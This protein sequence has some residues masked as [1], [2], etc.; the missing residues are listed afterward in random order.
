MSER[1]KP[2]KLSISFSYTELVVVVFEVSPVGC[3]DAD[4]LTF[5]T[6]PDDVPPDDEVPPDDDAPPDDGA[7]PDG[8]APP[9]EFPLVSFFFFCLY[10]SFAQSSHTT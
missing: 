2:H 5:G 3:F 10:C 7:P 1:S 9:D 6:E 8:G 4:V